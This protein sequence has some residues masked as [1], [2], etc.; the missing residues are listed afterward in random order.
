M[1]KIVKRLKGH[2]IEVFDDLGENFEETFNRVKLSE[3][4]FVRWNLKN[5]TYSK[6]TNEYD[7]LESHI[8]TVL[9]RVERVDVPNK[10]VKT[11]RPGTS[12][13]LLKPSS[14]EI[15]R[16]YKRKDGTLDD[17]TNTP[18][19][20]LISNDIREKF[21]RTVKEHG[22]VE[23]GLH[24][25]RYYLSAQDYPYFD[26]WKESMMREY[27][28]LSG[29]D[30]LKV[31]KST[32]HTTRP[33]VALG[34]MAK[35]F[36]EKSIEVSEFFEDYIDE[37]KNALYNGDGK[38][39]QYLDNPLEWFSIYDLLLYLSDA[40]FEKLASILNIKL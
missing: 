28:R 29:I 31:R 3:K 22:H 21:F 40:E 30:P 6:D 23:H 2:K 38:F 34:E 26:L 1:D 24:S 25:D 36:L 16:R 15:A 4:D 5:T 13:L 7:I 27:Q 8:Y 37:E 10:K 12:M 39:L 35:V 19:K 20:C 18:K 32:K 33:I 17:H 11:D 14:I 9:R